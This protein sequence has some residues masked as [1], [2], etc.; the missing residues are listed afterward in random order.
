MEYT[1]VI[2][3]PIVCGLIVTIQEMIVKG[4]NSAKDKMSS[5]GYFPAQFN[6][7]SSFDT[8]GM[9]LVSGLY[10]IFLSLILLRFIS[11]V[12]N[13]SD[14]VELYSSYSKNIPLCI[15]IYVLSIFIGRKF[16][17]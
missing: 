11:N 10:C 6:L 2:F 7:S 15:F 1:A 12:K 16:L 5:V 13:G 9:Q 14:E 17:I 3:A 4:M 8:A